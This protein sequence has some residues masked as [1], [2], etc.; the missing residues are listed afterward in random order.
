MHEKDE[1]K[2]TFFLAHAQ[3]KV[4]FVGLSPRSASTRKGTIISSRATLKEVQRLQ[5]N[6]DAESNV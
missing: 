1:T 5:G 3:T 4:P 2:K 6:T